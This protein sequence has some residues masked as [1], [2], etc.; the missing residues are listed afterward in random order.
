M[1][2]GGYGRYLPAAEVNEA[3]ALVRA[4]FA[5]RIGTRR[6]AETIGLSHGVLAFLFM[7]ALGVAYLDCATGKDL[8]V[9]GLYLAPIA[10]AA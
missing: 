10:V 1:S 7:G 4:P 3:R 8:A 2:P 9:W 5:A 6:T